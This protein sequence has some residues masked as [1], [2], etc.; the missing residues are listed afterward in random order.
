[1]RLRSLLFLCAVILLS[2]HFSFGQRIA[3]NQNCQIPF[4]IRAKN[5]G[6]T[7]LFVLLEAKYFKPKKLE[8]LLLCLSKNYSNLLR[9]T[10][11]SDEKELD[12]EIKL[13]LNPTQIV[14]GM[15]VNLYSGEPNFPPFNYYRAYFT[16]NKGCHFEFSPNPY[17]SKLVKVKI[18][19]SAQK[20][21]SKT[22]DID[23]MVYNR[24]LCQKRPF[25][26]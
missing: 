5:E 13:I 23:T 8:S 26:R 11:Y 1:M 12:S 4:E 24:F 2:F 19:S 17:K 6:E 16:H 18:K 22:P 14:E 15:S 3:D 9:V 10:A 7:L 20:G 25:L 21:V